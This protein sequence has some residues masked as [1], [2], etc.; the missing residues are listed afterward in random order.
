MSLSIANSSLQIG[1][2]APAIT[3]EVHFVNGLQ[4]LTMLGLFEAAFS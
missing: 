1:V 3:V 4:P 2:E